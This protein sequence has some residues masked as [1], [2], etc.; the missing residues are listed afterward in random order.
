MPN[1]EIGC[2]D[3]GRIRVEGAVTG[4]SLNP[5]GLP[6]HFRYNE[7]RENYAILFDSD[8]VRRSVATDQVDMRRRMACRHGKPRGASGEAGNRDRP[9]RALCLFTG[10]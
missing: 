9:S 3:P 5:Q 10:S 8:D 6:I 4:L 1:T 2:Q 7:Q